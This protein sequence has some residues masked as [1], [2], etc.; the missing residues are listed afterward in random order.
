MH[1]EDKK[2]LL[3]YK[4]AITISWGYQSTSVGEILGPYRFVVSAMGES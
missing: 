3:C 2:W 1:K 4:V